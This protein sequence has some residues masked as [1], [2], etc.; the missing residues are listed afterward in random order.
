[1]Q[2][3]KMTKDEWW[4]FLTGIQL[5]VSFMTIVSILVIRFVL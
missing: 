4:Y 1:M 5:G 3:D 2:K